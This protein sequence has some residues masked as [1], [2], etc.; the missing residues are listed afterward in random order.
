MNSYQYEDIYVGLTAEFSVQISE[1]YF[2]A[3]QKYTGDINPLHSDNE[4]A[5]SKGFLSKVVFGMLTA[6]YY[7]TLVGVYLPGERSLLHS[8]ETKFLSP[9]YCGDTLAVEGTV[10]D[11]NDLFQQ[12]TVKAIIKNQYGKKVSKAVLKVGVV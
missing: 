11:K 12:I 6:S 8:I 4:Y 1:E 10:T 2:L 7:S 5:F 3:F 9:V